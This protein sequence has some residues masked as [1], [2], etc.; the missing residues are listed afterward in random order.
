MLYI[1]ELFF[2]VVFFSFKLYHLIDK[3]YI[4]SDSGSKLSK[5]IKIKNPKD[6]ANNLVYGKIQNSNFFIS[7]H[8]ALK[9]PEWC[10]QFIIIMLV[11]T[12]IITFKLSITYN[13]LLSNFLYIN[14]LNKNINFTSFFGNYF[15][16]LKIIYYLLFSIFTLYFVHK[17]LNKIFKNTIKNKLNKKNE[18][19]TIEITLGKDSFE[20]YILIKENGFYQNILIT[21]SIGSGKTSGAIH[22]L[23]NGFIK[24]DIGGLIIDVKGNFYK[25]VITISRLYSREQDIYVISLEEDSCYNPLDYPDISSIELSNRIVSVLKIISDNNNSDSYWLDKVENY[26]RDFITIIRVYNGFVNFYEIHKLVINKEY[27]L[28]K[29]KFT[30]EMI[31][32]N[33]FSDELLFEL[34]SAILNIKQEYILLDE[35]TSSIIRSEIT[36]MTSIFVSEIKLY[37]KFCKRNN[38][39]KFPSNKIV[40]LSLSIGK[41]KLLS[42]IISTYLKLDFQ[43][44]TLSQKYEYIPNFFICD[45]Y[46]EVAN[47]EDARFFSLS[48]EYKCINII[49][50]QSYSSLLNTVKND[51]SVNVIIQ[52]FVNKIWFRNDDIY[53][54]TESIKLIGKY[55]KNNESITI[56][57][58]SKLS[59]YSMFL[60][61]FKSGKSSISESRSLSKSRDYVLSEEDFTQGLDTYEAMA[62]ISDGKN[63]KFYRKFKFNRLE[64]DM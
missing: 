15:C 55:L 40:V 20:N 6:M 62:I 48:R 52:N 4:F 7:I 35:R 42:K 58:N 14:L 45:E 10:K 18:S 11:S 27:L 51:N 44:Q 2:Y 16:L 38:N 12:T 9:S 64:V 23:L 34:D 59:Q 41:N 5:Y 13:F 21:G 39:L 47:Q 56:G 26:I 61:K 24:N 31:L 37:N 60:G 22:C 25:E 29:I 63:V 54:V 32:N 30:K 1:L 33:S 50:I 53:T 57:E 19:N 46:Q 17:F 49:S 28:E 3:S 43:K 8:K 36:R